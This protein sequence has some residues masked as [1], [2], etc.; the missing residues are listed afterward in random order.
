MN[1]KRSYFQR[2]LDRVF[3]KQYQFMDQEIIDIFKIRGYSNNLLYWGHR[4]LFLRTYYFF[5]DQECWKA[6]K[7]V[8]FLNRILFS[9]FQSK[10]F[11]RTHRSWNF[12][13]EWFFFFIGLEL[14][15]LNEYFF[16][17]Q[18]I[19]DFIKYDFLNGSKIVD[20]SKKQDQEII[21]FL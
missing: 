17:D 1:F 8:N 21:S 15:F 12:F 19:V 5:K 13:G 20:F 9:K 6:Q 16:L 10:W 7:I 18:L 14:K 3:L 2:P 11:L 4:E